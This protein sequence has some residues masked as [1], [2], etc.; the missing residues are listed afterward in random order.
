MADGDA[1]VAQHGRVRQIALP[2]R[3][4]QLVGQEAQQGVRQAEIAFGVLEIDR[5]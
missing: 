5:D 4:R 2:A 3:D 1:D